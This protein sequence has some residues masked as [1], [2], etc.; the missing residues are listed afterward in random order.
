MSA[1]VD[2]LMRGNIR[3]RRYTPA[4]TMVAAWIIAETGV[5]PAMASGSQ[6]MSGICADF[7]IAPTSRSSPMPDATPTGM[8]NAIRLISVMESVVNNWNIQT[9]AMPKAVSPTRVTMNAFRPAVAF[10]SSRYQKPISA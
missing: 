1:T 8:R 9:I 2:A 6:T 3:M 5:G 10:F 4:V 7:P